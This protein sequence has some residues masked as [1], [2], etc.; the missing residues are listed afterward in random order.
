MFTSVAL[1][2]GSFDDSATAR[3]RLSTLHS[4]RQPTGAQPVGQRGGGGVLR[5]LLRER[6]GAADIGHVVTAFG[7]ALDLL[8]RLRLR[9]AA[10][11]IPAIRA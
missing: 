5:V 8:V 9:P 4:N 2:R 10:L 11:T 3:L 1:H 7:M 6:V